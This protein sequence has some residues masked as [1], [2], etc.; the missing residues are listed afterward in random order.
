MDYTEGQIVKYICLHL[1]F[2][3][4]AFYSWVCENFKMTLL[5]QFV[6]HFSE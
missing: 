6:L 4:F 2:N 5:L 3:W 1:A